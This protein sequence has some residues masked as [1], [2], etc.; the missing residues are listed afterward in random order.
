MVPVLLKL[1]FQQLLRCNHNQ[2]YISVPPAPLLPISCV[3]NLP[4]VFLAEKKK[5]TGSNQGKK[6]YL[7][8]ERKKK[9]QKNPIT[10][11]LI[12]HWSNNKQCHLATLAARDSGKC[13]YLLEG[14][15]VAMKK[16]RCLFCQLRRKGE[17]VLGR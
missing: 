15:V 5:Q 2:L 6:Q 12:P 7:Q 13:K 1:R 3:Q 17:C 14:F 8:L 11:Q 4:S 16:I 9:T 10:C